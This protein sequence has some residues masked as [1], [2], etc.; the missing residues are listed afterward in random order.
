MDEKLKLKISA[1]PHVRSTENT[2]DIMF[3]V[4][5]ALVPA[6]AYGLYL[7]GWYAAL[8]VLVCIA[9]CVG[10][11]AL[12]QHCMGRKVT[13]GDFSAVVTGLLLGLNLPPKLP[14][15]MAVLGSCF[16]IIVVKQLFGGLGQNFM[17]PA[18]GARCFLILAFSRYMTNFVYDGVTMATPLAG[19]KATGT[20]DVWSMFLGN[21]AGTIGETSTA[22]LLLGAAYLIL[23]RIISPKIPLCYIGTFAV[24]ITIY[25]VVKDYDVPV[26]LGAHI[27]GGGLMLGAFFMATD[28]VTSPITSAGKVVYGVFLGLMTFVLR[29]FG[30]S[31]EGV[32]YSIIIANL[33]VPL[34][35]K[36]TQPKYF[37]YG[38]DKKGKEK[39][40]DKAQDKLKEDKPEDDASGDAS[41][42]EE[43]TPAV[44]EK[45]DVGGL[46]KAVTAICLI[47]LIM[48]AILGTVY[49]VTKEPIR[50]VE[51]EEAEAAFREVYPYGGK[52]ILPTE[53]GM[54]TEEQYQKILEKINAVLS[55]D[56]SYGHAQIEA[57]RFVLGGEDINSGLLGYV[58]TVS[59]P[60]G[61]GGDILMVVG[62]AKNMTIKGISF[63]ELNETAGLGMKADTD[64][65]KDQFK[66]KRVA[67]F[68]YTKTGSTSDSE[69]DAISGA[70]ITTTAVTNM[71]NAAITA[72][73]I[74]G[75]N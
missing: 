72:A 46:L 26:Y 34:I 40:K 36:V 21:T 65:F 9:S 62:I 32:S 70:T 3:D 59:S 71:V 25:A 63:L 19:L 5:L 18:L 69:I 57:L 55:V 16:A 58:I 54:V 44:K 24:C 51:K 47:T 64:D 67:G 4:V 68:S 14:I 10:F 48:G 30:P 73:F 27:C 52:I 29:V 15:W 60:K 61:Y 7:F 22:A 43:R 6:T 41:S 38:A 33:L 50:K 66:E 37:G 56:D 28:Y 35:E 53:T 20:A 13:V 31:A 39:D 23:R 8:L 49:N 74:A 1:S 11:E 12:Y 2:S 45:F 17:N 75:G 42:D